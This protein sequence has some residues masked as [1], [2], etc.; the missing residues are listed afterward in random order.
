VDSIPN[1]DFS[2]MTSIRVAPATN[3]RKTEDLKDVPISRCFS[4]F[5]T[6]VFYL[7]FLPYGSNF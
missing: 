3:I 7:P 2:F 1:S 4:L 5:L 6:G